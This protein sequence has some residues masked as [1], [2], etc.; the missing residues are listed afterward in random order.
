MQRDLTKRYNVLFKKQWIQ[1]PFFFVRDLYR[2]GKLREFASF[3]VWEML[4]RFRLFPKTAYVVFNNREAIGLE[5]ENLTGLEFHQKVLQFFSARGLKATESIYNWKLLYASDK[6][7][8]FGSFYPNDRDLY[9]STDAGKTISFVKQFPESIKSIFVSS[10]N[11]LFVCARG[12]VYRSLDNGASF[13]KTLDLGSPVSFFRFNNQMTETPDKLLVI[14]EYGNIWENNGWRKLAYVYFSSDNGATW[15]RSEFFI[16]KGANKHVHIVKYSKLLNSL[17]VADGDNYKRL[18][19]SDTLDKFDFENPGWNLV[20]RFHIQMGGHTSVVESDGKL[21]FGTDYQGGTNFL[22]ETT[23]GHKFTKKIVPD[24]YRRSPIDNMVL[25]KSKQGNEIWA[26]LPFSTPN[27]KCLLMYSPDNGSTW[28]K[29]LEYQR[30]KHSV[31]L[32]SSANEPSDV[33]YFAVEDTKNHSRVVY[34][35]SDQD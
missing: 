27:T 8:L 10:Q 9:K 34:Q 14:G 5:R 23:D 19:I 26:N 31:W 32:I 3:S 35:I 18:W 25:R 28:N 2:Y 4:H 1:N 22:I 15:K 20:N 29:V 13:E 6:G 30:S 21:L 11:A 33:L 7:E 16:Q 17:I 24:P 12:A